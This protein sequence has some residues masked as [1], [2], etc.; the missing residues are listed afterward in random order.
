MRP[1]SGRIFRSGALHSLTGSLNSGNFADGAARD[2]KM[3]RNI[4]PVPDSDLKNKSRIKLL[5]SIG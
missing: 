5:Q 3:H 4:V 2:R 1:R